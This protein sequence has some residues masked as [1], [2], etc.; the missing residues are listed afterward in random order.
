MEHIFKERRE[1]LLAQLLALQEQNDRLE[2]C[3]HHKI[4]Q[5]QRVMALAL[6]QFTP[7]AQSPGL[8]TENPLNERAAASDPEVLSRH[9]ATREASKR[10]YETLLQFLPCSCHFLYLSLEARYD[11]SR[12][13]TATVTARRL[14]QSSV[15]FS[16]LVAPKG[17]AVA[18]SQTI[19]SS[20]ASQHKTCEDVF[21]E[22]VQALVSTER[23]SNFHSI[24]SCPGLCGTLFT[25]R[26]E[27][28]YTL[29]T[30]LVQHIRDRQ[31]N[32]RNES[33]SAAITLCELLKDKGRVV[34][35][36]RL[37]LAA[38]L[39]DA[40]LS[41]HSSPWIKFWTATSITFLAGYENSERPAS[42]TPHIT[43]PLTSDH[44]SMRNDKAM[45][46]LGIILL[47]IGGIALEGLAEMEDPLN[48]EELTDPKPLTKKKELVAIALSRLTCEMGLPFKKVVK[49]CFDIYFKL[50]E[51]PN[52]VGVPE[53]DLT[54]FF[55]AIK[56]LEVLAYEVFYGNETLWKLSCALLIAAR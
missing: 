28:E 4:A 2:K 26:Q 21:L 49:Q 8:S 54:K 52:S 6:T 30:F 23:D 12:N 18:D 31:R 7:A 29:K 42:W 48:Q 51:D 17:T 33:P 14:S 50:G 36:D 15:K 9:K 35:Y 46:H 16:V 5:S 43:S 3:L 10:L 39:G 55:E 1:K 40:A 37:L 34:L 38:K 19:N 53:H 24:P 44:L 25:D 32:S 47:E 45:F 20:Q 22:I 27:H 11:S 13:P 56:Q 41:F